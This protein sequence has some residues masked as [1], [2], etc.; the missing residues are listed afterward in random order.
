MEI[1]DYKNDRNYLFVVLKHIYRMNSL[2]CGAIWVCLK[3]FGDWV[4]LGQEE[5]LKIRF[6]PYIPKPFYLKRCH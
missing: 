2:L 5:I 4:E 3:R 1:S 6:E